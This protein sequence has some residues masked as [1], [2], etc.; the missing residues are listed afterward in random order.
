MYMSWTSRRKS[1]ITLVFFCIVAIFAGFL[2]FP[3]VTR[4]PTCFDGRHNGNE[5]GIDC[6]GE[7]ALQCTQFTQDVNIKWQRSYPIV[8]GFYNAVAYVE[9]Q[10][11]QAGTKQ[12]KYK[13]KLYD[14]D[15]VLIAERDGETFIEPNRGF[16]VL[17]QQIPVGES[18]PLYTTF[19]FT[20]PIALYKTDDR[21][22]D[23]VVA[24]TN[25]LLSTQDIKPRFSATLKNTSDTHTISAIDAYVVLYDEEDNAIQVGKTRVTELS[26]REEKNIFIVWQNKFEKK[27][28]RFEVI[29]RY[30]PFTQTY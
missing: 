26:P 4:T 17:E 5:L 8:K 20:D 30:N 28:V 16:V 19:T 24:V 22:D 13:F 1:R 6:G 29:P 9:N 12:I 10:N 3:I 25:Q 7:C 2:I 27:P 15:R 11:F 21:Y 23:L 18:V 14:K